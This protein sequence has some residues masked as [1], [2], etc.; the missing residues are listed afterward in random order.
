M[1]DATINLIVAA[2]V[3][4]SAALVVARIREGKRME[5]STR[6]L[7]ESRREFGKSIERLYSVVVAQDSAGLSP[8]ARSAYPTTRRAPFCGYRRRNGAAS[9]IYRATFHARNRY[10][11][12]DAWEDDEWN[13]ANG[14]AD[15][16]APS[17]SWR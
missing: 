8:R 2:L 16:Y 6:A 17:D 14:G 15:E 10:A 5:K 4:I 3:V 12:N 7:M 11:A 13:V 9:A 1:M